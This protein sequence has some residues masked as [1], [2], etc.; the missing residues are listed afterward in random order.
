M[1]LRKEKYC[2]D[3]LWNGVEKCKKHDKNNLYL[4]ITSCKKK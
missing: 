1:K 2:E 4:K 3:C